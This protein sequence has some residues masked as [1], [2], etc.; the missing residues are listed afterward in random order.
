MQLQQ[1]EPRSA[2]TGLP[3]EVTPGFDVLGVALPADNGH[4]GLTHHR[5]VGSTLLPVLLD[6]AGITNLVH[7]QRQS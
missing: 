3:D 7:I 5:P 2:G 4:M 6:Q 1:C